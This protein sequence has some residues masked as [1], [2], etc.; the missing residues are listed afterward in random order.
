MDYETIM[1]INFEKYQ[2]KNISIEH[3]HLNN[4]EKKNVIKHLTKKGYSYCGFGYDHNNFDYLFRKK[5]ILW[6]ILL[7]KVLHILKRKYYPLL[8]FFIMDKK[9]L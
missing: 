5:K 9:N 6:N 4:S 1:S 3:L 2:I 8:N 7:S